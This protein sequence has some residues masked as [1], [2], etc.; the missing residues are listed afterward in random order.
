MGH[1]NF[2]GDYNFIK[3]HSTLRATPAMAAVCDGSPVGSLRLGGPAGSVGVVVRKSSVSQG[4]I[5]L[6]AERDSLRQERWIAVRNFRE[7]IHDLVVLIDNSAPDLAID[8][9]HLQVRAARGACEVARAALEHHQVEH[10][11]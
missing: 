8:L 10:G 2:L 6:C 1:L 11:C 3:I 7:A 5:I 4:R 9:A